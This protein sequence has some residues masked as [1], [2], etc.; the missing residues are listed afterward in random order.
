M[1]YNNTGFESEEGRSFPYVYLSPPGQNGESNATGRLRVWIQA[2]VHGNEPASDQ[3]ILA[4]LGEMDSNQ[5]WAESLLDSMDIMVLPRY[6]PDGVAYFQR[7]LATNYDPNRDHIKLA[8]QQTR[9]IKHFINSFAPHVVVDMHEYGASTRY[10]GSFVHAADALFS[11]AKNLNIDQSIRNMSE[12]LFAANMGEDLAAQGFRWEPYVTGSSNS[13][14]GSQILFAEAG[15][16]AKIGRNAMGLTQSITFLC[17][18]RGI[19]LADQQF[20]RRT[21]AGLAMVQSILQ[22]A[23]DNAEEVYQTVEDGAANFIDG[24]EEIIVT[25]YSEVSNRTYL[26]INVENGTVVE[27]PIQFSSTTPTTANL[28]RTRPEFYLIPR[29]WADIAARMEVYG[30]EVETLEDPYSGAV[31][32]FNITSTTVGS[33]YYEGVFRVTVATEPITRDVTLPPGSFRVSTRQKNAA[34]AFIALEPEN[35]D[36]LAA[37]NVIPLEPGDEYPIFRIV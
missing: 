28:T 11:A 8:R 9:D 14:P 32:T 18:T 4:L 23:A 33:V 16:D 3:A 25:D 15:S 2:A 13:T 6:N 24:Q 37:F 21:A 10:G 30:L 12:D 26:M 29:A 22:T 7:T 19:G 36:S 5:T 20:Q 27:Q 31:E 35:I 1:T 17:E 34:L